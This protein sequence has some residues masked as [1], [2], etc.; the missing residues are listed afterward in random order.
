MQCPVMVELIKKLDLERAKQSVANRHD[1]PGKKRR[2][3][4]LEAFLDLH[5]R[6]CSTC[7]EYNP[8]GTRFVEN[9]SRR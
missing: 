1:A 6:A 4:A 9:S 8:L 3:R 2:L 5:E 7:R